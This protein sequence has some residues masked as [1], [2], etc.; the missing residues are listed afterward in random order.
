MAPSIFA[1]NLFIICI[2]E[3]I[4]LCLL[5]VEAGHA[6]TIDVDTNVVF[7]LT[8]K[9]PDFSELEGS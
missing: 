4:R 2:E 1:R 3:F 7:D 5:I 6:R 9:G 8:G